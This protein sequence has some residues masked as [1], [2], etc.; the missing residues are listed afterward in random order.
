[1]DSQIEWHVETSTQRWPHGVP[2]GPR[3]IPY[4]LMPKTNTVKCIEPSLLTSTGFWSE[5]CRNV[6]WDREEHREVKTSGRPSFEASNALVNTVSS[7][8][9][10]VKVESTASQRGTLEN[11]ASDPVAGFLKPSAHMIGNTAPYGR[12][13]KWIVQTLY[14]H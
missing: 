11:T 4:S 1:M 8:T 10:K 5:S 14:Q 3:H 2:S 9:N 7:A 6:I 12:H 13:N